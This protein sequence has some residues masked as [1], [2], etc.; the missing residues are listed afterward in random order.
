MLSA[1]LRQVG[2]FSVGFNSRDRRSASAR[3]RSMHQLA[4]GRSGPPAMTTWAD[5]HMTALR[6]GFL[7]V[8]AVVLVPPSAVELEACD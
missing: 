5:P 1:L 8:A 7:A 6:R 3:A 2:I 4:P